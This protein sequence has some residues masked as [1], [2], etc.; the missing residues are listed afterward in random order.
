M[1]SDEL[2]ARQ[3]RV[4][5]LVL[6]GKSI[7]EGCRTARISTE[8]FYTWAK[9]EAF[10]AEVERVQQSIIGEAMSLLKLAVRRA[11]GNLIDLMDADEKSIK[12]R[13]SQHVLERFFQAREIEELADRI[14]NLEKITNIKGGWK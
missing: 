3:Q 12:L 10:K 14:S 11:V 13:A 8:T 6:S 7:S 5:P 2:S 9:N 1:K 4:I